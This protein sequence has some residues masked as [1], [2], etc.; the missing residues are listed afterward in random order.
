MPSGY[1]L[2]DYTAYCDAGCNGG[3]QAFGINSD[4]PGVPICRPCLNADG[5]HERL[6]ARL[7]KKNVC[8][9][10]TQPMRVGGEIAGEISALDV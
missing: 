6:L 1:M 9:S 7:S 4:Q 5:S 10:A 8:T 3:F 2:T